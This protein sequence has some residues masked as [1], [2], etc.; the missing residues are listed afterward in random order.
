M[1]LQVPAWV[2]EG[3]A[4][5]MSATQHAPAFYQFT[6]S[7]VSLLHHINKQVIADRIAKD[8]RMHLTHLNLLM[9][10][11]IREWNEIL[12]TDQEAGALQYHEALLLIDFFIH[13]DHPD[14]LY[15]RRYLESVLSGVEESEARQLHLMRGRSFGQ[16]EEEIIKLWRPLGFTINYQDRG[17]LHAGDVTVDWGAGE[18]KRT[19]ATKR[20]ME[21]TDR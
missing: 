14:G 18:I 8:R 17:E 12:V 21:S 3:I 19:I 20:A 6:S 4:E 15:F 7:H 16:I 10:R 1:Y 9:G 5:Y 11:G 13:R 2:S